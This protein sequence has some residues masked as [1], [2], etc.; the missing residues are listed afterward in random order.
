[1]SELSFDGSDFV[2]E[3]DGKRLTGQIARVYLVMSDR[4]WRS[5]QEIHDLIFE[6]FKA[7]DPENSI[8]A[9]LRNL[10][11]SEFGCHSVERRRR[12]NTNLSEYQLQ[13]SFCSVK[14]TPEVI[15]K[16]P[17]VEFR[18]DLAVLTKFLPKPE[19]RE[20]DRKMCALGF[21]R[22]LGGGRWAKP[23]R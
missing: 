19:W 22:Y 14:A 1:M 20:V 17:L 7:C 6:R 21:N 15:K 4:E 11:K 23:K 2:Q 3:L 18:G 16:R 8:Q 9:Q 10:R 5:V 13:S 12:E